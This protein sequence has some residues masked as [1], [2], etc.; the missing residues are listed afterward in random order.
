MR[1]QPKLPRQVQ[2]VD[3]KPRPPHRFL[4]AS[5]QLAMMSPAKRNSK[6]VTDLLAESS[7][8]YES[9]VVRIAG[10]LRHVA[11]VARGRAADGAAIDPA[12][13][14]ERVG[15]GNFHEVGSI[16]N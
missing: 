14:D 13:Y 6:L 16:P 9:Q 2:R 15:R 8:L 1:G 3:P 10:L 5:V 4:T 12:P 11:Q 7:L